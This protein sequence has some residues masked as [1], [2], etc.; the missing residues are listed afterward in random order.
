MVEVR[1]DPQPPQGRLKTEPVNWME[2]GG[3]GQQFKV[4]LYGIFGCKLIN[5]KHEFIS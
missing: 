1:L 5:K 3:Y 4:P 2:E